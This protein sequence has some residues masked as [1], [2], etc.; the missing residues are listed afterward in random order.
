[1]ICAHVHQYIP[2]SV[3][4]RGWV[5]GSGCSTEGIGGA[6]VFTGVVDSGVSNVP[7]ESELLTQTKRNREINH[8][9]Y[10]VIQR[11]LDEYT[12]KN[13]RSITFMPYE[14]DLIPLVHLKDLV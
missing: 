4:F 6:A 8:Q 14:R 10:N 3:E 7:S 9:L 5:I 2:V 1:M 12:K 13:I 11:F